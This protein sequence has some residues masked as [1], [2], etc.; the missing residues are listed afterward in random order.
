MEYE[1]FRFAKCVDDAVQEAHEKCGVEAHRARGIEQ[2]NEPQRLDLAT[3]PR[4][5]E[6]CAAVRDVAVNGA[7]QIEPA[8][9]TA[10]LLAAHEPRAHDAGKS[11]GERLRRRDVRRIDYVPQVGGGECFGARSAFAPAAPV[12]DV[13]GLAVAASLDSVRQ[14]ERFLRH[15]CFS[16][17]PRRRVTRLRRPCQ[18]L[19]LPDVTTAPE[20]LENLVEALPI[21]MGRAEQRAERRLER[22]WLRSHRRCQHGERIARLGKADTK[23]VVAQRMCEAGKPPAGRCAHVVF[24][25]PLWGR[26]RQGSDRTHCGHDYPPPDARCAS[27]FPSRGN[28]TN[29]SSA[30]T[31]IHATLPSSRSLTSRVNRAL[32]S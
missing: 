11:R 20:R 31:T 7:T 4:E 19:S 24:A 3:A 22:A 21:G 26:V 25:P 15:L 27:A 12:G 30:R 17:A 28:A 16:E 29:K 32:S 8:A 14:A 6:R 18:H 23:A 9:A 1:G 5:I 13:F 2:H 10:N